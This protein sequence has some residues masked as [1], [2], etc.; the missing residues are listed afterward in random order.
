VASTESLSARADRLRRLSDRP[1]SFC[2]LPQNEPHDFITCPTSASRP[3]TKPSSFFSTEAVVE[4][5]EEASAFGCG[6]EAGIASGA[7]EGGGR[8]VVGRAMTA[9]A[10]AAASM[11]CVRAVEWT[12]LCDVGGVQSNVLKEVLAARMSSMEEAVRVEAQLRV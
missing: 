1:T 10:A 8:G 7:E 4:E 12:A 3:L 11:G 6:T 9:S 2:T 5:D